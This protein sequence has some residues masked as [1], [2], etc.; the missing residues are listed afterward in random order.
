MQFRHILSL[1]GHCE[2]SWHLRRCGMLQ[3]GSPFDWLVSPLDSVVDI[4]RDD[5]AR[6]GS[7]FIMRADGKST[8]CAQYGV[9]YHH[10]FP[11]AEDGRVIFDAESVANCASKLRH[12]TKS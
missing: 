2:P 6:L 8:Y 12:N 4:L 3:D 9:L 1:G 11:H 5:G 7:R 10:E